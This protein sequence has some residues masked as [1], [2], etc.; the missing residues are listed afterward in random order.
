MPTIAEITALRKAGHLEEALA[1]AEELFA[2]S[3]NNY[4]AGAIFWCLNDQCKN[5]TEPADIESLH[6]RMKSLFEEYCPLDTFMPRSLQYI[7]N[8]LDPLGMQIREATA[9]AKNGQTNHELIR[10]IQNEFDHG[11]MNPSLYGG[12]GWLIY[13]VLRLT[14]LKDFLTRKRHLH[15]YLRLNLPRPDLLHSLIL[16]EAVKVEQNTPL[17][18]RIRDFMSLWGWDNLR[19]D[20]WQQYHTDDGHTASSLV[21]KLITVYARELKHDGV[22]SPAEFEALVD[23]ALE[24]YPNNQNMPYYKAT[25]LK[26]KG[27]TEQALDYYK[28]LI[29]KS[30][31]K[32]YLWH[33]ASALV[34][35]NDLRIAFLCK[36]ISVERDEKF[37]GNCRLDLA[38][39]LIA[40]G[41]LANTRKELEI[42]CDYYVS[43]G[44]H[45]KQQYRDI[46]IYVSNTVAVKDNNS[47]YEQYIPKA[48]EFIY[49][50]I[51]SVLAIKVADRQMEDRN[52]PG[53]KFTQWTLRT[54]TGV[55]YLKKPQRFGLD[56][57]T[58]NGKA[59][60]VKVHEGRIV[61]IAKS[62]QSPLNQDWIK[63]AEGPVKL[64]TDR[65]GNP[66]AILDGVYVGR[67]Q[68]EGI[69][70][71]QTVKVVA[72]KKEDGRWSA[73]ALKRV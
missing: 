7:E 26:S 54:E 11:N 17:Q 16:G 51:P 25:V 37:K 57:G 34:E 36:A 55:L 23:K 39:A 18:F 65:N 40:K 46:E 1:A 53:R 31:S 6:Q 35:D 63:V 44:F 60:D 32:C 49:S 69:G 27:E 28:Q 5:L 66:Y 3:A 33:H 64:R 38:K 22:A 62:A 45:L 13:Q 73:I 71:M 59:F 29:L 42:Y 41:L 19:E 8:R 68:L 30:P 2:L 43:Q 61:W 50:A 24:L 20:D 12:Y 47:L 21:E 70:E 67:K 56:S 58:P 52:H 14:P 10:T 15:N 48:D 4:T 72:L 9:A